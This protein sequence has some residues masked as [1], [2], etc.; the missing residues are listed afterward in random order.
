METPVFVDSPLAISATEI[1]QKN[2][3]LFEEETQEKLR[4]GDNP[5]EFN[6]LQFTRTADESKALNETYYPS[7]IISASGMC[8]IG[9]IKHHLKHNLWNPSSTILFVGYQAPG[10][11]GR[12]IVDGADKVK[13]FGEDIS[14]NSRIEYIEGYSGHA[15]QEW[16]MNFVYSFISK[17]K[18]IF[19]VH[20]EEESQEVLKELIESN[21]KIPVTIPEFG[22]KY[23]V[24]DV[25]EL[26]DRIEYSK[27]LEDQ[28]LRL[29]ILEK[30]DRIKDEINDMTDTVKEEKLMKENSDSEIEKLHDKVKK[31]EDQ[32][33]NLIEQ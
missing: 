24:S 19:L 25:P 14:I 4:H 31:L 16:L 1:F 22:E 28:F 30:L 10:T 11:L 2:M 13:I 27:K 29:Q 9:R 17:P 18:H 23:E 33:K 21:A 20:G 5:L 7:I 12:T 15:D 3:D 6:G 26:Q 8:D 32:I